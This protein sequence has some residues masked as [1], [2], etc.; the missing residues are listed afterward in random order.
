MAS[1]CDPRKRLERLAEK[2]CRVLCVAKFLEECLSYELVPNGL[3]LKLKVSIG[4]EPED[5]ELQKSVDILLERTSMHI[6]DIVKEGHLRKA[7]I[8][9]R[10]I[11]E[12]RGKLRKNSPMKVYSRSTALSSRKRKTGRIS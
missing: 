10:V 2:Q 7:K 6:V 12:E 9:G 5:I 4:N 11:E 8:L 3:T 1:P